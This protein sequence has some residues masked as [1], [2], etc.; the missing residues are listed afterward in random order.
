MSE[1][2]GPTKY[3]RCSADRCGMPLRKDEAERGL[4]RCVGC[5][6]AESFHA[7]TP[8]S[9][10]LGA[11]PLCGHEWRRHDPEDGCC[12]APHPTE[13]GACPCGRDLAFWCAYNAA[14]STAQLLDVAER[15]SR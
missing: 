4:D 5:R 13:A 1:T 11:C 10:Q 2:R 12:D 14:K 6:A 8:E 9:F 3:G 7:R 15:R